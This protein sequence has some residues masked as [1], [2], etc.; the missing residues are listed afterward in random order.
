MANNFDLVVVG[1]GSAGKAAAFAVREAGRRVA[2]V[3][4]L[5]FGGTCQLRGCDPK[6]ILV[7][8][9]ELSDWARRMHGRG[10]SNQ[11]AID[12]PALMRF[13]RAFTDPVPAQEEQAL[14]AAGISA[15]HGRARFADRACLT[16]DGEALSATHFVIA[17]GAIPGPLRVPGEDLVITSDRFLELDRLPS[18]ILFIGGGYISFEFAHVSARAGAKATIVH[19]GARPLEGFDA[20]LVAVLV[21]ASRAVGIDVQLNATVSA[22]ERRGERMQVR[23]KQNGVERIFEA[24]LAVHGA[25]RVPNI[26]DLGLDEAGVTV[27]KKGVAVNE[28]LQSVSNSSVYAA[29]DAADGGGL[30]LTPV[31]GA[32]GA[33]VAENM[34]H[35]NAKKADLRVVPSIVYSIPPLAA[36]GL[37]QAQAAERGLRFRVVHDSMDSWYTSRRV[38]AKHTAFKTLIEE[39]TDTIIGAHV[40]GP[41]APEQINAFTLAMHAGLKAPAL[42]DLIFAYPTGSSDLE[43]M[44]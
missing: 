17:A 6:K 33:V 22:I 14:S 2:I 8:A 24:D 21:E 32:E 3:D 9:A 16:V 10:V 1:T 31:A 13:K 38:D 20:D 29:G 23:A 42:R 41:D 15:F 28:Y 34:M 26:A 5:P 18:D 40:I 37:T 25:G 35:G 43:Y 39:G 44:L 30:P 4:S 36:V 27:T 19:R 11:V 7:G 12:W